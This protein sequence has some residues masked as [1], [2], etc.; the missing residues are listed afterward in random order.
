MLQ[1]RM[2]INTQIYAAGPLR[3]CTILQSPSIIDKKGVMGKPDGYWGEH[4][5]SELQRYNK[6]HSDPDRGAAKTSRISL[7]PW[8][9]VE[10]LARTR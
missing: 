1:N 2:P 3:T 9:P 5:A 6:R 7:C 8:A 10:D 4:L